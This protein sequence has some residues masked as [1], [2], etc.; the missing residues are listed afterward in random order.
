[1]G[2]TALIIGATGQVGGLVLRELLSSPHF[3]KVG[4]FGRRITDVTSLS[5]KN[6]LIQK[7]I[8]FE[9]LDEA[10]LRDEKWDVV[11]ITLGTTRKAAQSAQAFERIDREYVINAARAAK[12]NSPQRIVYVSSMGAD[13]SSSFLYPKSK[14][15][16]EIGLAKLGYED[17]II[18]RPGFLVGT[19]RSEPRLGETIFGKITGIMSLF[20]D[21][22][23]I[24]ISTL[25]KSVVGA[26][27]LGT[28]A[29]PVSAQSK[30]VNCD[31]SRF[32]LINNSGAIR[33]FK[34][35]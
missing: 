20:T 33:F 10:G 7:V 23:Q 18:F 1:M 5:D 6:K 34:D 3:S 19:A 15:L 25:A 16:T 17:V 2:T 11:F 35:A 22:V 31:D 32:T 27:S 24:Q 9:K 13:P 12:S 14:G 30:T 26:G 29:L 28:S 21:S 8:D 4:E